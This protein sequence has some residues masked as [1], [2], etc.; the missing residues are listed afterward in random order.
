MYGSD[1]LNRS[2]ADANINVTQF[3]HEM[4]NMNLTFQYDHAVAVMK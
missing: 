2:V 4:N 1:T 3:A